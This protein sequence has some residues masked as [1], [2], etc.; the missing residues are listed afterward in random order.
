MP[1][2]PR[3]DIP[4]QPHHV[5]FRGN[6]RRPCFVDDIDRGLYLGLLRRA[7]LD[8][9]C[10]IHAYV[11]MTNHVHLL[12]TGHCEGAI[13]ATMRDAGSRFVVLTNRRHGRTGTLF[14]GR[15]HA[16]PIDTDA[17]LLTCMRY[18]EENPV[19][20]GMVAA[21][22][23][24]RWSSHRENVSG[25]PH[26]LLTPHAIY[27]GLSPEPAR[28]GAAYRALF[29]RALARHELDAIRAATHKNR[30]LGSPAFCERLGQRLERD[31][32]PRPRGRPKKVPE[33]K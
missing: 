3:I 29:H 10:A 20:A 25:R 32:A 8:K 11:L 1:R 27:A 17:Y 16:S 12:V 22:A 21:P 24:Y 2:P 7:A 33:D 18:V 23:E 9:G 5:C 31:V 4:G 28:R 13:A 15:Y 6:D 19:R 26:G 30:A 14:E